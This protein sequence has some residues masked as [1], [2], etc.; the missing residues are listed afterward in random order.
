[1]L[2]RI[3]ADFRY[4]KQTQVTTANNH[5]SNEEEAKIKQDAKELGW[6]ML[7]TLKYWVLPNRVA[8]YYTKQII[9]A[10][11]VDDLNIIPTFSQDFFLL[12]S[13]NIPTISFLAFFIREIAMKKTL[14]SGFGRLPKHNSNFFLNIS[15]S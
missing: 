6:F 7:D 5:L 12:T 4:N 10:K 14:K 8:T 11:L 15:S 3:S 9:I 1:M 13:S 2:I